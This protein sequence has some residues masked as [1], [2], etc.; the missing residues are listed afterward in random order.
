[1]IITTAH[2]PLEEEDPDKGQPWLTEVANSSSDRVWGAL[3]SQHVRYRSSAFPA[4]PLAR[5]LVIFDFEDSQGNFKSASQ[6]RGFS[7]AVEFFSSLMVTCM[8]E[9]GLSGVTHEGN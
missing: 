4:D 5:S 8:E 2:L 7:M 9:S 1:M 3:T 6:S